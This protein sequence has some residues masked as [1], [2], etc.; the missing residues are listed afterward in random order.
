MRRSIA[1]LAAVATLALAPL[2]DS[3]AADG[4]PAQAPG[5][6]FY[7]GRVIDM[8]QGWQGARACAVT[9]STYA[10]CFDSFEEMEAA[11]N[12]DATAPLV[13]AWDG[14][15]PV[16]R[17]AADCAGDNSR[18]LYL[19]EHVNFGGRVLKFNDVGYW[20]NL[21]TYDFNDQLSSWWNTTL[22]DARIAQ[23]T[24]GGGWLLLLPDRTSS[25]SMP[26][27]WNDVAS[28]LKIIG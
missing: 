20:Q 9:S 5:L 13:L 3:G 24:N 11:T 18:W 21:T 27:G 22:C 7:R 2:T 19:Y 23:D 16:E 26:T 12:D 4:P 10:E 14:A 8:S 17:L 1:T 25:S 6:A 15:A 28:S